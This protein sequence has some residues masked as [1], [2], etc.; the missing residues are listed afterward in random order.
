MKL[1]PIFSDHAVFAANKRISIFGSGRGRATVRLGDFSID[2]R[3]DT[4]TWCIELPKMD[5]GGPYTL[6]FSSDE[7]KKE[8][9]EKTGSS[10]ELISKIKEIL[11][12][13]VREVRL[14]N[15]LMDAPVAFST[16]GGLSTSMEKILNAMPNGEKVTASRILE[17]NANHS[18]LESLKACDDEKLK[19]YA[20]LLFSQAQLIDG[21]TPEDPVEFS[22]LICLLM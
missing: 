7:E 4:D 3:S 2:I 21:V 20:E 12:E 13:R 6:R 11:G 17:I 1:N 10:S 18:I 5:Y 15:T 22:R 14:S 16:E 8:L 19:T 9:E